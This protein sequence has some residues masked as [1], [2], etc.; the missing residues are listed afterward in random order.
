[1]YCL[2]MLDSGNYVFNLC[3][4]FEKKGYVFEVISTPCHIAKGGCGYCLKF[5]PECRELVKSEALALGTP[6]RE[7]YTVTSLS[8]RNSY[9]KT[10]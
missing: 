5:P 8:T 1:M 6:V 7:I 2:A 10:L 3:R 9:K 4:A